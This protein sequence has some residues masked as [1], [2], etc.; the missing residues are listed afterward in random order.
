MKTL[1]FILET[2]AHYASRESGPPPGVSELI[3]SDFER[4]LVSLCEW[5]LVTP[6]VLDS[7]EALALQPR[8]SRLT[9]ERMRA[10]SRTTGK[11]NEEFAEVAARLSGVLVGSNVDFLWTHDLAGPLVIYPAFGAR[12]IEQ[13]ELLVKEDQWASVVGACHGAGFERNPRDPAFKDGREALFYHQH[14]SPCV[15]HNER[16]DRLQ[17]KFRLFDVGEPEEEEPAWGHATAMPACG[18]GA[19]RLGDEDLFLQA[20]MNFNMSRLSRLIYAVD[21][22]ILLTTHGSRINWDY[23]AGRAD[24]RSLYPAFYLTVQSAA[25]S[26][27]IRQLPQ[28]LRSPGRFRRKIF[29]LAWRPGKLGL[30]GNRQARY[31][32]LDRLRF[33]L[34][35][36]GR[37]ADKLRIVSRLL[38][39]RRDWV[40]NFFGRPY[41]PWYRLKFIILTLK[42]RLWVRPT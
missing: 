10:L 11:M 7:L 39:P 22:G 9:F 31:G 1:D 19:K 14:Y 23:I 16:N 33:Y 20:W 34:L 37:W 40:V 6:I 25:A 26:L 4:E 41:R 27:K 13:L 29:F 21:I 12:P 38:S 8:I 42:N 5:H 17:L 24:S 18:P 36:S 15:L 35:E 30:E 2:L 3:E 28:G 32:R